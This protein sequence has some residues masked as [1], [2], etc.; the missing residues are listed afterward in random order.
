MH[1]KRPANRST[2]VQ[3]CV[4]DPESDPEAEAKEPPSQPLRMQKWFMYV[5]SENG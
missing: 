5:W 1:V 4:F 2:I 3:Q